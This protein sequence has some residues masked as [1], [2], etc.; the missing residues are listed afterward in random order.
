MKASG[1]KSKGGIDKIIRAAD[2]NASPMSRKLIN[3][4]FILILS[5]L[6]L[7][8]VI[9]SVQIYWIIPTRDE[10]QKTAQQ[11]AL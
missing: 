9:S 10:S 2:N 4:Q 6:L 11:N 8:M 5:L 1:Q 3:K 7:I